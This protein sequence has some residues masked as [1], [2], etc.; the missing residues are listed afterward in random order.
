MKNRIKM[1]I[2]IIILGLTA[3]LVR[4][5]GFVDY[6]QLKNI[7]ELQQWIEEIGLWGPVIYSLLYIV[8]C[9]FFLPKL[10]ITLLAG[11]VF[12]PVWGTI[13]ASLGATAGATVSF[14]I[15]RYVARE[16]IKN[17]FGAKEQYQKI[18]RGV[19]KYGWRMLVITRLIPIFPFNIQNHLYGLTNIKLMTYVF[20]SWLGMLPA[21]IVYCFAA[22]VIIEGAK[23]MQNAFI[24]L[25]IA[26][27][28]FI[29]I[30]LLPKF[31]AWKQDGFFW[32]N[33]SNN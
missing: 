17:K 32:N 31:I 5:F 4:Y 1:M 20:V 7:T 9:L 23:N 12:G 10:P 33:N 3:F 16:M 29:L 22:G 30:S 11:L 15:S 19:E 26:I 6:L 27:V 24:Y 28:V 25:A 13:W 8:V 21:T 2:T 14:L 18:E